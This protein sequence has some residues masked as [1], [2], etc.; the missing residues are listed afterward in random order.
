MSVPAVQ[1]RGGAEVALF[2]LV[3][4]LLAPDLL[5]VQRDVRGAQFVQDVWAELVGEFTSHFPDLTRAAVVPQ[6][7]RHFL[8]GHGLAVALTLSPAL[9]QLLLVLGDEVECAAAAVC[10]LD[11]VTQVGVVQSFVEVFVKSEL[12]TS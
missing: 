6:S 1:V 3:L 5:Q 12:L 9:G 7:S 4:V 2:S 10:P 8:I 11:R